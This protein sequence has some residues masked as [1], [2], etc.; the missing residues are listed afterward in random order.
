MPQFNWSDGALYVVRKVL[1]LVI[2]N[3]LAS[4]VDGS[5]SLL[6]EPP[7]DED[8]SPE[9]RRQSERPQI[10]NLLLGDDSAAW[11]YV[12]QLREHYNI[13]ILL[14]L[15][16]EDLARM[17]EKFLI[18]LMLKSSLNLK[19]QTN[20]Y[21]PYAHVHKFLFQKLKH[22]LLL[23]SPNVTLFGW[24]CT[25]LH[26]SLLYKKTQQHYYSNSKF[27]IFTY[28]ALQHVC[29]H[30]CCVMLRSTASHP[31]IGLLAKHVV[32]NDRVWI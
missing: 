23:Q 15:W 10:E 9:P 32:T 12:P 28:A 1:Y 7:V 4:L 5:L 31:I 20:N 19:S 22:L 13:S 18:T 24:L 30:K 21:S 17:E 14:V 26:T 29:E 8:G 3:D 16:T 25:L 6:V 11:H 2:A 27:K